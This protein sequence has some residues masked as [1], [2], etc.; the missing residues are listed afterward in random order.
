MIIAQ[1]VLKLRQRDQVTE[2]PIRVFKPEQ[3]SDGT[4]FCLYEA[5]WPDRQRA[6][7]AGGADSMQALIG[8]LLMIG[9]DI[10]TSNYHASGDLY[11]DAPGK[12]YDLPVVPTLRD[13]LIGDDK[14]Y[15]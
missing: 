7:R 5:D 9:A 10:Y 3:E 6:S 12:G 4:W 2:I 13:L 11:F 8:A 1:R 14:K 15:L